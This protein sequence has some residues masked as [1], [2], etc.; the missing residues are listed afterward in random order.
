MIKCLLLYVILML[1]FN[2]CDS[3]QLYGAQWVIGPNTSRIDFNQG[4]ITNDSI[5]TPMNTIGTNAAISD[6]AGNL[7]FY[8]NGIYVADSNGDSI[9]NGNG[10]SPCA[11]TTQ[12][13]DSGLPL[14]QAAIFIPQPGNDQYIY[15]FHFSGDT[16]SHPAIL[17][18]SLIDR[19]GNAGKGEIVQKN[20]VYYSNE[21]FWR[22]GI[23]TCRAGNGINWWIIMHGMNNHQFYKFY[24]TAQGIADTLI[25]DIGPAYNGP[26]DKACACFSPDGS[27]YACGEQSGLII[28]LNFDRCNGEFSNLV[29]IN[30]VTPGSTDTGVSSLAFSPNG[31]FLYAANRT[32]L[33]QYDLSS[34]N[35][36]DSFYEAY[37]A[38]STDTAQIAFLA[39]GLNNKIYGST[40]N[41]G[42][43]FLHVINNPDLLRAA[44][45]FVWGG[46]PTLSLNSYNLPNMTNYMLGALVDSCIY[47]VIP[48]VKNEEMQILP[49]PADKYVYVE[50]GMQGNYEFDLLNTLGQVIDKKETR[51]VDIFDTQNL[52]NGIYILK[53]T[54]K[55]NSNQILSKEVVVQH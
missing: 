31:R 24:L 10:L 26:N 22:G 5:A 14:P 40:W 46:Q 4:I 44:C 28:V 18:Y 36:Q 6:S 33:K 37:L 29:M 53:V 12:Y 11:M 35:V 49:N 3:Q 39:L 43:R 7:L 16:N 54:D 27:K 20:V 52:A 38:D 48:E 51:H 9:L 17:Y 19:N 13:T 30:N 23:T 34:S 47:N 42:F 45:N 21:L 15:L 1:C 25:E 2:Y 41:G 55:Q 8:T 32:D 50:M